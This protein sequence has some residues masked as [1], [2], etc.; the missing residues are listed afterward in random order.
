MT[1]NRIYL[2]AVLTFKELFYTTWIKTPTLESELTAS[3][4]TSNKLFLVSSGR[5]S[6]SVTGLGSRSGEGKQARLAEA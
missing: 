3:G 4:V 2:G 6:P 1:V 5:D